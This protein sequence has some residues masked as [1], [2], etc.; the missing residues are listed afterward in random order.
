MTVDPPAQGYV[1]Y[2]YATHH[3][4]PML[5]PTLEEAQA[6]CGDDESP[7]ALWGVEQ[8]EEE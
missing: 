2:G 5:F 1:I 6:Y 7:I 8:P 3:E 4:P